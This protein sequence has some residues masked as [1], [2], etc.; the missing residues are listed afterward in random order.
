M[1]H[2]NLL[3]P[4]RR[5]YL[6]R[7]FLLAAGRYLVMSIVGGLLLLSLGGL[8]ASAILL[9]LTAA[10]DL[11][12]DQLEGPTQEFRKVRAEIAQQHQLLSTIDTL[13][14]QRVV[15]SDLIAETLALVPPGA[16]V[17]GLQVDGHSAVI[18][19]SGTAPTRTALVEFE[20]RLR[21]LAWA[22]SVDAPRDNLLRAVSPTYRFSI[23]VDL[24]IVTG[25][26]SD[27][28]PS[29]QP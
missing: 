23:Q 29:P 7:E 10:A 3:P 8:S 2:L 22:S 11:A 15:W 20:D 5:D 14:K 21:Q 26:P 28:S 16:T 17:N 9:V 12:D 27:V 25:I 6:R 24:A 18:T 1:R 13:G 19:F 4:A